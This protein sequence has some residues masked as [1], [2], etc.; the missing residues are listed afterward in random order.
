M[1]SHLIRYSIYGALFGLAFPVGSTFLLALVELHSVGLDALIQAQRDS[2]LLW[3]ID[4]APIW[5]GLFASFAGRRQDQLAELVDEL[6]VANQRLEAANTTLVETNAELV[7]ASQLKSQFLANMSHELRTPLNAIIGFSR[8]I[9]RKSG[10]SLPDRQRRNLQMVHES[11]QHLLAMVNDLLDIEHM[12]AGMMRVGSSDV[13]VDTLIADVIAKLTPTAHA[14][15][16]RLESGVEGGPIHVMTDPV[17][18]RQ[19]LDNLLSN[20]IKY[21]DTGQIELRVSLHPARD[22][23][24]V[25][26]AVKD[27]GLGIPDDQ[28]EF[29]FNPF[30][31]VDGTSTRDQGGVGLGLHL[32]KRL[33]SLLEGTIDVESTVGVGSTFTFAL[34]GSKLCA[35]PATETS[36]RPPLEPQG[37][38]PLVLIID[39]QPEAIEIMRADLIEAGYRVHAALSGK[40]GLSRAQEL[41]PDAILLDMIMPEMDGWAV[42]RA[43]RSSPELSA[44]PVIITSMLNESPQAWDLGIVGWLTKPVLPDQIADLLGRIGVEERDDVLVVEDDAPTRSML[45]QQMA[46]IEVSARSVADGPSAVAAIDDRLPRALILDLMLPHL[47]GFRVLEHLRGRPNGDAVAVIIYTAKDLTD[48]DKARLNGGVVSIFAKGA[49]SGLDDVVTCVGRALASYRKNAVAPP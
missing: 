46:D 24:E 34:P 22:P 26:F 47:D 48:E 5:L 15:G 6:N 18:L 10:D 28:V 11:G 33:A 13:H 4:S 12:E 39:D 29:V 9:L 14:K 49:D 7:T 35:G 41:K 27:Q 25:R 31:Q 32:V 45:L 42:L 16:L 3:V 17:R 21:S 19:V 38:G 8:I 23:T 2:P 36:E 30:H 1:R 44:V 20:A 37:E 43:V 40:E